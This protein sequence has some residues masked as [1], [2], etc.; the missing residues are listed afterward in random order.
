MCHVIIYL[1]SI[2]DRTTQGV[3]C[4]HLPWSA[5]T[6]GQRQAWHARMDLGRHTRSDDVGRVMPSS[7]FGNT[8][9]RTT[10]GVTC[11]LCPRKAHTVG[12]RRAWKAIIAHTQ[13]T[14]LDYLRRC[15]PSWPLSRTH[16]R[17]MSVMAMQSSL[18]ECTHGQ[19]T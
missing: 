3:T 16:D 4:H 9:S 12:R 19:M 8:H 14:R 11:N 17:S 10:L 18:L 6:I 5:H 15:M 7:T 13:H 2:H 1:G